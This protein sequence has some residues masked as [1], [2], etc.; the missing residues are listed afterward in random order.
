MRRSAL[1]WAHVALDVT[2]T[3]TVEV[4]ITDRDQWCAV[5]GETDELFTATDTGG[6]EFPVRQIAYENVRRLISQLSDALDQVDSAAREGVATALELGA[7]IA[8]TFAEA[9]DADAAEA[10]LQDMFGPE[11]I[12]SDG[13]GATWIL[14]SCD[15]DIDG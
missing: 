7:R 14:D 2:D 15:V 4:G 11:G 3:I 10:A 5:V 8:T 6:D 1:C 9:E 13:P 12:Q